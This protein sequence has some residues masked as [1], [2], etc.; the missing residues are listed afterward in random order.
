[1][2][3]EKTFNILNKMKDFVKFGA[4]ALGIMLLI[5]VST[6]SD[7]FGYERHIPLFAN[8]EGVQILDVNFLFDERDKLNNTTLN[9]LL[10]KDTEIINEIITLHQTIINERGA[11]RQLQ[12]ARRR[13]LGARVRQFNILYKLNNGNVVVRSYY[14]P[15]SFM[16]ENDVHRLQIRSQL[17]MSLLQNRPDLIN[18]IDIDPLR[19]YLRDEYLI[20]RH[21]HILELIDALM[22]D[23]DLLIHPKVFER[24]NIHV[25]IVFE[26]EDL[27]FRFWWM[28]SLSF[29]I[30]YDGDRSYV[31]DWLFEKEYISVSEWEDYFDSSH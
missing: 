28:D 18:G 15:M 31:R 14:L 8:I 22:K 27:V 23:Y 6:R 2:I 3:A 13:G 9:E 16:T 17:S 10:V 1:M 30:G 4:I 25:R 24:N 5:V 20:T 19:S 7:V 11:L 12:L 26:P 21:D 29:E